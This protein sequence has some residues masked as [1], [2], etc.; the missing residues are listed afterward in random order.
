[1]RND[2]LIEPVSDSHEAGLRSPGLTGS[3]QNL[4]LKLQGEPRLRPKSERPKVLRWSLHRSHPV[5][6]DVWF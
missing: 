5:V 6:L 3:I 1:M 2:D 4:M